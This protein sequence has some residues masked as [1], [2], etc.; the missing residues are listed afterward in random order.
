MSQANPHMTIAVSSKATQAG[1]P[2]FSMIPT[3]VSAA[4]RH[5]TPWAK[6][7]IPEALKMS[8]NPSATSEYMTPVINPLMTVSR[9]KSASGLIGVNRF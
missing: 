1:A 8:T 6:L 9:K 2:S 7:K 3:S 4:N 5:M